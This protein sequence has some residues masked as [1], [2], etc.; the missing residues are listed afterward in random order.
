MMLG[1]KKDPQVAQEEAEAEYNQGILKQ[2]AE[3]REI[4]RLQ[5]HEAALKAAKESSEPKKKKKRK[6]KVY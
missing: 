3:Q 4:E 2:L 5:A 6:K 1:K